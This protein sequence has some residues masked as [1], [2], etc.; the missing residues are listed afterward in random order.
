[1]LISPSNFPKNSLPYWVAVGDLEQVKS[2]EITAQDLSAMH[3]SVNIQGLHHDTPRTM[4]VN[5]IQIAAA[6]G[7]ALVAD[8]LLQKGADVHCVNN[9]NV[10]PLYLAAFNGSLETV[11]VLI[12]HGAFYDSELNLGPDDEGESPG[13]FEEEQ[14][15]LHAGARGANDANAKRVCEFLLEQATADADPEY[16][17]LLSSMRYTALHSAVRVGNIETVRYLIEQGADIHLGCNP[18]GIYEYGTGAFLRYTELL[19]TAVSENHLDIADLLIKHNAS[20]ENEGHGETLLNL[21]SRVSLDLVK[22]LVEEKGKDVNEANTMDVELDDLHVDENNMTPL[23]RAGSLEIAQYLIDKGANVNARNKSGHTPLHTQCYLGH[24]D[25]FHLL[26]KHGEFTQEDIPQLFELSLRGGNVSIVQ[27]FIENFQVNVN[28]LIKERFRYP[29]RVEQRTPLMISVQKGHLE[30]AEFLLAHGAKIDCW[31][32]DK[33]NALSLANTPDMVELLLKH[34]ADIRSIAHTKTLL[35]AYDKNQADLLVSFLRHGASPYQLFA[36][37]KRP[38]AAEKHVFN[39][40]KIHDIAL[41]VMNH[42]ISEFPFEFLKNHQKSAFTTLY[43]FL[44]FRQEA[45]LSGIQNTYDLNRFI[46]SIVRILVDPLKDIISNECLDL[47]M[48][49]FNDALNFNAS[50]YG[51]YSEFE[52]LNDRVDIVDHIK[53]QFRKIES[54]IIRECPIIGLGRALSGMPSEIISHIIDDVP[55]IAANPYAK[56]LLFSGAS[57]EWDKAKSADKTYEELEA[58][59]SSKKRKLS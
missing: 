40:L 35:K 28:A 3:Q 15:A 46:A 33:E 11:K 45:V 52:C 24:A 16:I 5:L 55:E 44:V 21:A 43:K 26:L 19:F 37:D 6:N 47:E 20:L 22:W 13:L 14:T 32:S 2:M 25:I 4:L 42:L 7:H 48:F 38:I 23:H 41:K 29:E 50:H 9:Y 58:M 59:R 34:G 53:N 56:R 18:N 51:I 30:L 17:N 27:Y 1:M 57:I 54:L 49:Q 36:R 8:Y 12:K 39:A 31:S 10:F